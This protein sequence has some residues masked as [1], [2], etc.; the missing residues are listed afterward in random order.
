MA[1][2]PRSRS[3]LELELI[4]ELKVVNEEIDDL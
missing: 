4:Q 3:R 1:N 2:T